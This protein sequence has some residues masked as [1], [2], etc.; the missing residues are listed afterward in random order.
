MC[1]CVLFCRHA[2]IPPS[3]VLLMV[4]AIDPVL[5]LSSYGT[6]QSEE[7]EGEDEEEM[8]EGKD[9]EERKEK[10]E[11]WRCVFGGDQYKGCLVIKGILINCCSFIFLF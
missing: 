8:K 2:N 1:V 4:T 5:H 11:Q 9:E 6:G 3:S 10:E 7:K